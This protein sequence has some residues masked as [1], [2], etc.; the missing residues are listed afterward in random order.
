ML[1]VF[2]SMVDA[3]CDQGCKRSGINCTR[4]NSDVNNLDYAMALD[5][6]MSILNHALNAS[7]NLGNYF[8]QN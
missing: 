3:F 8:N 6:K 7:T 2:K 5:N 1:D 4:V